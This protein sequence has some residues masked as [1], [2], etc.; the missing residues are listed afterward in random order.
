MSQAI[1]RKLRAN[2]LIMIKVTSLYSFRDGLQGP[3]RHSS[4]AQTRRSTLELQPVD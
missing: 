1:F 3:D 4:V 2:R